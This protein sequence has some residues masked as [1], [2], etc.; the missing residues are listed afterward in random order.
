MRD[1]LPMPP[2]TATAIK[3]RKEK[4]VPV[5]TVNISGSRDARMEPPALYCRAMMPDCIMHM[6]ITMIKLVLVP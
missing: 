5:L 4:K 2:I 6:A 3:I 1:T